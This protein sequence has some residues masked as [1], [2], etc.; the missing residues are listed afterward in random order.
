MRAIL[1]SRHRGESDLRNSLVTPCVSTTPRR[2]TSRRMHMTNSNADDS[3]TSCAFGEPKNVRHRRRQSPLK[4]VDFVHAS[5]IASDLGYIAH[6]IR[7]FHGGGRN[8]FSQT[9][10][11]A[12]YS[13]KFPLFWK[14][15]ALVGRVKGSLALA[16]HDQDFLC[17]THVLDRHD[18][19]FPVS[20][21]Q[22]QIGRSAERHRPTRVPMS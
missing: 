13:G 17:H 22:E 19:A 8:G 5:L 6:R 16:R 11:A 12:N 20:K 9:N 4:I 21:L 2:R 1:R 7:L 18:A 15:Q 14:L 10:D 3:C